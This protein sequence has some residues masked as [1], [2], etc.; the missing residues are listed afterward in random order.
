MS[1]KGDRNS[2]GRTLASEAKKKGKAKGASHG[3]HLDILMDP[4]IKV[5]SGWENEEAKYWT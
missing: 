2:D 3:L 1:G 5:E 4:T